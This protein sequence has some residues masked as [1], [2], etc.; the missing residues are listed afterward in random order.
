MNRLCFRYLFGVTFALILRALF[1]AGPIGVSAQGLVSQGCNGAFYSSLSANGSVPDY[2]Y[3]VD[4]KITA[5]PHLALPGYPQIILAPGNSPMYAGNPVDVQPGG[6]VPFLA[7]T[8]TIVPSFYATLVP[9][10]PM[11]NQGGN[12][13]AAIPPGGNVPSLA[14][15]TLTK[16]FSPSTIAAGETSTLTFTLTNPAGNPAL[17]GLRFRDTLPANVKWT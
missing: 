3:P 16:E 8:A 11:N 6:H 2:G 10:G 14:A 9:S 17:S 1:F 13:P 7:P 12:N 4:K 15:A 5:F